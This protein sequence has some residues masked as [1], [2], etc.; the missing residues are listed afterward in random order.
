VGL[1]CAAVVLFG[2]APLEGRQEPDEPPFTMTIG[3]R[4]QVRYTGTDFEG[5]EGSTNTVRVQRARLSFS[6]AAYERFTYAIQA[7]LV[8]SAARLLD[9]NVRFAASDALTV[10]FGQGK[11]YFGRQWLT[12]SANL[13]FVDRSIVHS[14]FT[15]DRQQG[16]ALIGRAAEN[17]L[18][19]NLAVYNGEGI[20]QSVNADNR[21]MTV[22]RLVFTPWG[23]Y[24]P[25][26]SAHDYPDD[27][28]LAIG[29]AGMHNTEGE[30][31]EEVGVTRLN[32]EAAFKVRGFSA[33]AEVFHE[34]ADPAIGDEET[35]LGWYV[36][37]GYLFPGR[38]HELAGR[39]ATVDP[40]APNSGRTEMGIAYSYYIEGHSAKVQAD[41]RN[42]HEEE[43]DS[44]TRELRIQFQLAL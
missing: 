1:A 38:H 14:R 40:D 43:T 35:T 27:P 16:I 12:S 36:Q 31:E 26:E 24:S 25:T 15:V 30:E 11:A 34:N 6:G 29:I 33:T 4:V 22:G 17:R 20:G 9:A 23:S 5:D 41:V 37:G 21:F 42:I 28:R 2:A 10:W 3:A 13:Q 18:E 8:G 39:V 44:D 7:D 19:A 32:A